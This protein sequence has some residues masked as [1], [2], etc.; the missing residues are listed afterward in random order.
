MKFFALPDLGEGLQEAEVVAWH[1]AEGDHVV[2]DQPLVSVETDK[3][4]VEVPSPQA[5]HVAR[6]CAK[7]HERVKVGAPLV[8]FEGAAHPDE[9]AI[10]GR[11][12]EK[13]KTPAPGT[14]TPGTP[15]QGA[16]P[17]AAPAVR[18][19]AR[20]LG[21]ELAS[22]TGTGPGGAIVA[23]DIEAAAKSGRAPAFH[24]EPLSA[25]RRAMADNMA[26]AHREVVP[27]TVIDDADIDAW[28][29]DADVT[30]RLIRAIAKAA[31][32]VPAMNAWYDSRSQTVERRAEADIAIA[33]DTD[34]G[35]IVPVLTGAQ[36]RTAPELAAE[37]RRLKDAA[38]GRTLKPAELRGGSITLSN[39]G[40]L[41]GR[42]AALVVVPPQVAIV[43][44]GRAVPRAV[45]SA[46]QAAI[47]RVLPLS[48]T[49]D[50]RAITG[51]EAARFLTALIADLQRPD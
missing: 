30:V 7:L 39:F 18:A 32:A 14:P 26:R 28:P 51:A 4:V 6:L 40:A 43:G 38:R 36:R 3:A 33:V 1:V 34:A 20:N 29:A 47:H 50:H 42:Y 23:A 49:F 31:A 35:L 37:L 45:A 44:A 16:A 5:G 21:I 46:G 17:L 22:V 48:L 24:G 19:L 25:T 11:L 15:T 10:V 9:G 27:A 41:G 13:P 2:A 12:P 8:E